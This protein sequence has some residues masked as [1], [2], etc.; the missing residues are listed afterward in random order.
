MLDLVSLTWF[1]FGYYTSAGAG[2][3]EKHVRETQHVEKQTFRENKVAFRWA[4]CNVGLSPSASPRLKAT[5]LFPRKDFVFRFA[6]PFPTLFS[7]TNKFLGKCNRKETWEKS[8]AMY[9]KFYGPEG[10][11]QFIFIFILSYAILFFISAG[12]N[13]ITGIGKENKRTGPPTGRLAHK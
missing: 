9:R 3:K 5:C 8:E 2:P 10:G 7:I 12:A 1:T 11:S 4:R 13:K 6:L